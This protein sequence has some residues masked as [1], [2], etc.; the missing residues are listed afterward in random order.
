MVW[1]VSLYYSRWPGLSLKGLQWA[2][3]SF[4][5]LS[6]GMSMAELASAAPTSGGVS[7]GHNYFG[8]QK[9]NRTQNSSRDHSF[10]F[11]HTPILPPNAA[12]SSPGLLAVGY[13]IALNCKTVSLDLCHR[14]KHDRVYCLGRIR[15]LG[16][17][18]PSYG[19]YRHR[20]E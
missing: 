5:I 3:A 20:H 12:I 6:I 16:C 10:I 15:R 14:F 19:R 1:G 17:G 18:C 13:F 9:S 7:V 2:V 11:G 8:K 4:F